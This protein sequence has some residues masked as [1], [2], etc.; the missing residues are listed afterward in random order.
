MQPLFAQNPLNLG[1]LVTSFL[2]WRVM[3]ASVDIRTFKRL[4]AGAQRQDKGSHVVLL[5]LIGSGLLL[6]ILLALKV[7]ATAITSAPDIFFWLG[8]V[9][10][11]TGIVLRLYAIQVL[12]RSFTT[13]VAIA[14]E[15]TVIEAGPYRFIRHP[16]Y[17]GILITLLGLGLSLTNNWLSL[18]VIMG[19]ALIGFSYRI[20]VEEHVLQEHLGQHY[21]EYMRRTKRLIPFVL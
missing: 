14:P 17:T 10:M 5:C 1:V 3:E 4:R 12:G 6:G 7:P 9:L 16:S 11:Y 19:C 20:R 15:Q 18:L 8:I 13:S 21:Q 2:I